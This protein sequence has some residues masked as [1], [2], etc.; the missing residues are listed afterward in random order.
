MSGRVRVTLADGRRVVGYR[1]TLARRSRARPLAERLH[2][3]N[4]RYRRKFPQGWKP[5]VRLGFDLPKDLAPFVSSGSH[6][7]GINVLLGGFVQICHG[8]AEECFKS[9]TQFLTTIAK[10]RAFSVLAV[11][12]SSEFPDRRY[13]RHLSGGGMVVSAGSVE[14]RVYGAA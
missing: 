11:I 9:A 6:G 7:P 1:K 3:K 13:C 14:P 8:S 10:G 2:E 12:S 5:D 4:E